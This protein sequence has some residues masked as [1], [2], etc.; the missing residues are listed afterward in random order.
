MK[1]KNSDAYL[2][3]W[4]TLYINKYLQRQRPILDHDLTDFLQAADFFGERNYHKCDSPIPEVTSFFSHLTQ[5]HTPS[6]VDSCSLLV[7]L[8][9]QDSDPNI[10]IS[11][12]MRSLI[13]VFYPLSLNT[14][15]FGLFLNVFCHFFFNLQYI[16]M[17]CCIWGQS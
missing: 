13:S 6:S 17:F 3:V 15:D 1:K 14:F 7:D 10:T 2:Q 16:Y 12:Y 8:H 5:N 4:T 9:S 11:H